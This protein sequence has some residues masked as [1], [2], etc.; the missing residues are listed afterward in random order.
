[1]QTLLS[2]FIVILNNTQPVNPDVFILT[3]LQ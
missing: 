1:L 2:N 3:W